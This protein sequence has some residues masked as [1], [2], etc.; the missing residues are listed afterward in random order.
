MYG[1]SAAGQ[2]SAAPGR[3][4][5]TSKLLL[6]ASQRP[7]QGWKGRCLGVSG[8]RRRTGTGV[9]SKSDQKKEDENLSTTADFFLFG[10][11]R[12]ASKAEPKIVTPKIP[13]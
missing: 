2:R 13:D 3:R 10:E 1:N 4:D 6:Q 9:G 11:L 8:F 7:G 12:S 5:W